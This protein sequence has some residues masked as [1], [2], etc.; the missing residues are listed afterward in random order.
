MVDRLSVVERLSMVDRLVNIVDRL[1][2]M[3]EVVSASIVALSR[4]SLALRGGSTAS[5]CRSCA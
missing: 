5:A 1:V 3:S 2:R 4:C